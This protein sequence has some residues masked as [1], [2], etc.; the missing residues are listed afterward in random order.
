MVA[1]PDVGGA[2][3]RSVMQLS[4]FGGRFAVWAGDESQKKF[5]EMV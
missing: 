1:D 3:E 2:C 4:L 5:M